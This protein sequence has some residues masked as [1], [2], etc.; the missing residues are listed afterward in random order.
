MSISHQQKRDTPGTTPWN[1]DVSCDW[2]K[3][4]PSYIAC[5]NGTQ[6]SPINLTHKAAL[7]KKNQPNFAYKNKPTTGILSNWGYGPSF[8]LSPP[9]GDYSKLPKITFGTEEA[10]LIGWHIHTPAEHT[11]DGSRSRAEMHLVH[12]TRHGIPR[13]VVGIF[14]DP[15]KAESKFVAGFQKHLRGVKDTTTVTVELNMAQVV[16]EA[17]ASKEFWAYEGSLTSPPCS[18]GVRWFV[19]RE[20]LLVSTEQMQRLLGVGACSARVEQQVWEHF[21][22]V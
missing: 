6:Q 13:S 11:I 12:V 1:Y 22:K 14:I 16:P 18:E 17:A 5:R 19:A 8:T 9:G 20:V 3:L 15:G 7:S 4:D 2:G 10:F 21:S